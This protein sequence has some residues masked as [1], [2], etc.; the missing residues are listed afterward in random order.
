VRL[1]AHT[2]IRSIVSPTSTA[3]F[4]DERIV[5]LGISASFRDA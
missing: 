1:R 2:L 3:V 5:G 4:R